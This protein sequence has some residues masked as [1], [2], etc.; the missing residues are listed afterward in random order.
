MPDLILTKT[1]S[2]PEAELSFSTSRSSGPGGQHVNTTESKVT[3]KWNALSSGVL[4]PEAKV[5]LKQLAGQRL[6]FDGVLLISSDAQRSQKRN[7]E[8]CLKRLKGL[9]LKALKPVKKRKPTQIPKSAIDARK[10]EKK[11]RSELK[12]TRRSPI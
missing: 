8:D 1:L 12:K 11:L 9:V 6:R 10:K 2:I 3:L 7:Q 5:R 4:S